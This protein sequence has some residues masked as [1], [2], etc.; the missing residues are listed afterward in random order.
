MG[1]PVTEGLVTAYDFVQ[2]DDPTI[3]YDL[4]GNGHHGTI[5]GGATWTN[6]GLLLDGASG[7]VNVG[8]LGSLAGGYTIIAVTHRTPDSS[9]IQT[10]FSRVSTTGVG[11]AA[12]RGLEIREYQ[13]NWMVR[14]Y[15][16]VLNPDDIVAATET[17]RHPDHWRAVTFRFDATQETIEIFSNNRRMSLSY[18]PAARPTGLGDHTGDYYIG[19]LSYTQSFWYNGTIGYFALYNRTLSDTEVAQVYS[20]IE[21]GLT[22]RDILLPPPIK[23]MVVIS[24][25]DGRIA[26]YT[27]TYPLAAARRIPIT[28]YITITDPGSPAVMTWDQVKELRAAGF[29][30][31]CHSY[32]HVDLKTLTAAELHANMQA[33][34]AAYSAI[35][36]PSPEHHA[37]PFGSVN[38]DVMTVIS[39]Y[40][41]TGRNALAARYS[42][43]VFMDWGEDPKDYEIYTKAVYKTSTDDVSDILALIDEAIENK[44]VLNLFT[45]DV[46]PT[47]TSV[48]CYDEHFETI[49]DYIAAKRDAGLIDPVTIDGLY[50]A[51][52]GIRT[53][54]ATGSMTL[55][56]ETTGATYD[57]T[58][59]YV[60]FVWGTTRHNNPEGAAPDAAGYDYHWI[61]PAG[62]YSESKF[63]HAPE[64]AVGTYY[65]RAAA[66]VDGAWVYGEELTLTVAEPSSL[67]NLYPAKL[68]SP[69]TILTA[70]YTTGDVLMTVHDADKLETSPNVVCLSGSVAGEFSYTGRYGN[71][72]TG[73][74]ALPGTPQATWGVGT[75]AFR[76][77]AA[78][79][80]NALIE[81]VERLK[82]QI[83]ALQTPGE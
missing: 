26:D 28:H 66:E 49:L 5:S 11:H 83:A 13:D 48:G 40:R 43:T 23:P 65:Y 81:T 14:H 54:P 32:G 6:E 2:G 74:T 46:S 59:D 21:T 71:T 1:L 33:V 31:E 25:D 38:A 77:I 82:E 19:R 53:H 24:T 64:L 16:G 78:Y 22:T 73:V 76:G 34:N 35:G 51:M 56:G 3:L 52:Q 45:H 75:F 8:D 44:Y 63:A 50:R 68:G 80:L 79:D 18:D 70:P 67:P 42:G 36:L 61:A 17:S 4:S 10:L 9:G 62:D 60:G 27:T 55:H 41:N 69:Y 72:L 58:V 12:S 39:E 57:K 7:C 30:I 20:A 29:G 37:Y 15:D 47:P